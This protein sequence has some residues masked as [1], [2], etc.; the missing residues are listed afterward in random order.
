MTTANLD[1]RPDSLIRQLPMLDPLALEAAQRN[2]KAMR[3]RAVSGYF[4]RFGDWLERLVW[5]ARQRDMAA[6]LSGATDHADLERRMR[7]L[8]HAGI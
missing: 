2:A 4:H 3:A 6:Y 7:S 8:H 5:R 1:Y